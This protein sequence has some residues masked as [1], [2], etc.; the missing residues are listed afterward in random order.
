MFLANLEATEG[1]VYTPRAHFR[2]SDQNSWTELRGAW[3]Q[4]SGGT[5]KQSLSSLGIRLEDDLYDVAS[6]VVD[7]CRTCVG[8]ERQELEQHLVYALRTR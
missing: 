2:L 7:R 3:K 1:L 8:D 4:S 6:A 5:F